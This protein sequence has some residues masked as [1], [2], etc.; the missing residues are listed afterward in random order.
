M[1]PICAKFGNIVTR[2]RIIPWPDI[3]SAMGDNAMKMKGF[4][5]RTLKFGGNLKA[6]H[7]G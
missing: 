7:P 2:T 6:L 4:L 3:A 5:K 1:A